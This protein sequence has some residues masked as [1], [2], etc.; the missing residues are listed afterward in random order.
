MARRP[1]LL[2]TVLAQGFDRSE[3]IGRDDSGRF[4]RG[5]RVRCSQ[6]EALCINGIATHEQGCPNLRRDDDD[7]FDDLTDEHDPHCTCPDCIIAHFE[8]AL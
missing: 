7:P 2:D 4:V 8:D 5:V 1:S 6:C 3:P